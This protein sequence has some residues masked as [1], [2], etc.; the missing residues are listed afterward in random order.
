MLLTITGAAGSLGR[1][2]VEAATSTGHRVRAVDRVGSGLQ[3][4]PSV[5][6]FEV[7]LLDGNALAGIVDGCDALI[8]LAAITR[9][10]DQPEPIVHNNNVVASYNALNAAAVAGVDRVC[11]ASSVNAVGGLYGT[12]P[13]YD[14]LPID[15]EHPAY[16]SDPYSL[17]KR[18]GEFQCDDFARRHPAATVVSLR[19]HALMTDETSYTKWAADNDGATGRDLWG[20]T[21][22]QDAT[23]ACLRSV[24]T[25]NPGHHLLYLVAPTTASRHA[26]EALCAKY[27]P[28]VPLRCSLP[29]NAG[30]F[31]C[32]R[33]EATLGLTPSSF[34]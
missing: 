11:F 25:S 22:M 18:I 29:G 32:S 8:H 15:E 34:A 3:A 4:Q 27:H 24:T 13:Q 2:L 31:N 17:S 16:T 10:G 23:E 1:H 7:D 26:T 9:P 30:L 33:V 12:A 20:Y 5:D 6:A 19:L 14:Y 21:K 28:G